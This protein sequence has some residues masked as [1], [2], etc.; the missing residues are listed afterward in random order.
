MKNNRDVSPKR[1]LERIDFISDLP[2]ELRD[3]FVVFVTESVI[4]FDE[5]SCGSTDRKFIFVRNADASKQHQVKFLNPEPPFVMNHGGYEIGTRRILKVPVVFKPTAPGTY[6]SFFLIITDTPSKSVIPTFLIG[7]AVKPKSKTTAEPMAALSSEQAILD[8][9]TS[10]D[11]T[12]DGEAAS[13]I[14]SQSDESFDECIKYTDET[15]AAVFANSS[16]VPWP[17]HSI[18]NSESLFPGQTCTSTSIVETQ[19]MPSGMLKKE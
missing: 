15:T 12:N 9:P 11:T 7:V 16:T 17:S 2:S 14:K 6:S 8:S 1:R 3:K 10:C 19:Y 13:R 18:A 4:R 5:T